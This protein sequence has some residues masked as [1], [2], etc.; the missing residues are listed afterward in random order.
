MPY[1]YNKNTAHMSLWRL[2]IIKLKNN[3]KLFGCDVIFKWH[4]MKQCILR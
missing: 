2:N 3:M 1:L 4:L